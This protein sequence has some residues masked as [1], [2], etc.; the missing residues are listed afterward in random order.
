MHDNILI[1]VTDPNTGVNN[2]TNTG[3]S[4]SFYTGL[5]GWGN[6]DEAGK[7]M[8]DSMNNNADPQIEVYV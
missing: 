8:I 1:N 5:I 7:V 2:G 3:A 4:A 6:A